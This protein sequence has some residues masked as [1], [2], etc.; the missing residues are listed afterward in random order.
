ML[1]RINTV[2]N[3]ELQAVN[4]NEEVVS[5]DLQNSFVGV[6]YQVG[7]V[8]SFEL[9]G[10]GASYPSAGRGTTFVPVSV[11]FN[12][13]TI[14]PGFI[15]ANCTVANIKQ[16]SNNTTFMVIGDISEIA[17][18]V[19]QSNISEQNKNRVIGLITTMNKSI[20]SLN[21]YKHLVVGSR[22]N[23]VCLTMIA[24]EGKHQP[25]S[26]NADAIERVQP[27]YFTYSEAIDCKRI[28]DL[29]TKAKVDYPLFADHRFASQVSKPIVGNHYCMTIYGITEGDSDDAIDFISQQRTSKLPTATGI[30]DII[31]MDS[32]DS[33]LYY[34]MTNWVNALKALSVK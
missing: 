29:A 4:I 32:L 20:E 22:V 9:N 19:G 34:T 8:R 5:R 3:R 25:L 30:D 18:L 24:N 14:P 13:F 6:Y 2:L 12:T 16:D 7:S 26:F 17:P 31:G 21:M 33:Y 15:I 23:L 1:V 11:T 10:F 28:N 27:K